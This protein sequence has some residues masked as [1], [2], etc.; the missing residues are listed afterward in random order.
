M[1]PANTFLTTQKAAEM[2]SLSPRTLEKMRIEGR[3]PVFRKLG[4][5]KVVYAM[6]D[7]LAW[8]DAGARRS[9]SDPGPDHD[10]AA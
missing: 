9:T 7:L 2:L 8:A 1:K 10:K 3:G 4:R 6:D 5:K